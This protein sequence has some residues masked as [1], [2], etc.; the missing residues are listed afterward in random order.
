[1]VEYE[2]NEPAST[3]SEPGN[4][5][6]QAPYQQNPNEQGT[7]QQGA[8]QQNPNQQQTYQQNAYQ[9]NPYEQNP[10][11]Q[12]PYQQGPYQQT[13]QTQQQYVYAQP[14]GAQQAVIVYPMTERDRKLR[15]AAFILNVI[16]TVVCGFLLVPLAWMIPMTV[17][18]WGVYKGTRT[19][20]VAFGIC[21][22][23]FLNLISGILLLVSTEGS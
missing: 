3:S 9:Q 15:L 21:T 2:P 19:N 20:T 10:Y 14:I 12:G 18:S 6:G 4:S 8:Y 16:S 13:A 5:Y 17:M 23:L 22:L 7:Y 11:Q 1:M